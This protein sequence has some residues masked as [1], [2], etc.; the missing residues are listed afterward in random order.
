[1]A[2]REGRGPRS[3]RHFAK[4]PPVSQQPPDARPARKEL[5]QLKRPNPASKDRGSGCFRNMKKNLAPYPSSQN[6][7]GVRP[8][9]RLLH[10][11]RGRGVLFLPAFSRSQDEFDNKFARR[12]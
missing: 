11:L 3:Q 6:D 12:L 5:T 7:K 1:M 9:D 2:R 10:K 8:L 4:W